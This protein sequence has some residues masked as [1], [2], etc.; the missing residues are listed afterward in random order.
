MHFCFLHFFAA[1]EIYR[2]VVRF[3][4]CGHYFC[5]GGFC[6]SFN[7]TVFVAFLPVVT[8]MVKYGHFFCSG[9]K[10]LFHDFRH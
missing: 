4:M 9:G 3:Q 5:S 10:A 8:G 2:F 7:A 1:W 6:Y